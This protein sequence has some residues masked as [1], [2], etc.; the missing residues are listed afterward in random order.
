MYMLKIGAWISFI[1]GAILL[2]LAI[3]VPES[4]VGL[5]LGAIACFA[6]G[7]F[8]LWFYHYFAPTM[9]NLPKPEGMENEDITSL[10][11]SWKMGGA[12]RKQSI[13]KMESATATLKEMN[14]S[15]RLREYGDKAEAEVMAIRD[16]GQLINFDPILEFDLRIVPAEGEA[17]HVAGYR[18][19]VS[20]IILPRITMGS[21]YSAFVDP[22]DPS[23]L[24]INWQ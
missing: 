11:G 16:T 13:S 7:G 19:V 18:Q 17:Y 12:M 6:A 5:V 8:N 10:R 3:I 1:V 4:M 21:T 20:K 22:D 2:V 9:R 23:S 15:N 14:R 24:F